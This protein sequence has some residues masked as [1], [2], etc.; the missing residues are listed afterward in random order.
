MEKT[1]EL[2]RMAEVRG[3]LAAF[4]DAGL[5]KVANDQAFDGLCEQVAD[6]IGYD[7]DLEKIAKSTDA[8]IAA[9]Y[10]RQMQKRAGIGSAIK[11]ALTA[12]GIRDVH[13]QNVAAKNLLA[14]KAPNPNNLPLDPRQIISAQRRL[15]FGN[16]LKDYGK[17]AIAPTLAYGGVAAALGG[18]AVGGK[19][20]YDGYVGE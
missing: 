13:A 5:I 1:A 8:V 20:A 7:Y 6:M 10:E 15:R 3:C 18:G 12:K 11:N 16:K 9:D 2:V 14:G 4:H 17:A 19:A